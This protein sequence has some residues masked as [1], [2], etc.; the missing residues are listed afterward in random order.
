MIQ[1][2]ASVTGPG[3]GSRRSRRHARGVFNS[4]GFSG[5]T[6]IELL[7]V[8]A[9]IGILAALLFPSLNRAMEAGRSAACVSNVRQLGLALQLY[10][11][12]NKSYPGFGRNI[13]Q[14]KFWPEMLRPYTSQ[15]WTNQLYRCPS[16]KG[17]TWMN[18]LHAGGGDLLGSYGYN[19]WDSYSGNGHNATFSLGS[20]IDSVPSQTSGRLVA[21]PP[22]RDSDVVS[23][24]DMIALGDAN[25]SPV[26]NRDGFLLPLS[27]SYT[28]AGLGGLNKVQC[29][30]LDFPPDSQ[31]ESLR[32]VQQ[33]HSGR[34]HV[35]FCDGHTEKIAHQRL[36]EGSD[37]SL[38][39]WNRDHQPH[40]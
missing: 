22:V 24:S 31:R 39:R 5:F 17:P 35:A 27:T 20:W 11:Q 19:D 26:N 38:R 3:Y 16:F 32:L 37:S 6:L 12:D 36:Y 4:I 13:G 15:D 33:R 28:V 10:V 29:Y 18:P 2:L 14:P 34:Y 25:L 1:E 40:K 30:F 9:I 23:P 21:V 7:V 8:I